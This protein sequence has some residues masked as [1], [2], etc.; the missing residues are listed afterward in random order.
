MANDK[1]NFLSDEDKALWEDEISLDTELKTKKTMQEKPPKSKVDITYQSRNEYNYDELSNHSTSNL[2]YI[3]H[4]ELSGMDKN[5]AEKLRKGKMNIDARLDLHGFTQD[6]AFA[7]LA[8]FIEIAYERGNRCLLIV[9]GKGT[10]LGGGVGV[11]RGNLPK[12]LNTTYIRPKILVYCHAQP[13][14]G[15]VGAV[16]ILLRKR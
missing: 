10:K 5:T 8:D 9:T 4:G 16:Y 14:D 7:K 3:N 13:K 15:G 11:L 12:W 6:K 1:D 2:P